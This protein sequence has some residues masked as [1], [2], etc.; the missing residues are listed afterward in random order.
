MP[1]PPR[2]SVV[3]PSFNRAHLLRPTVDSILGQSYPN[4]ECI[5]MDGGSTDGS[6]DILRSYGARIR[7]TSAPDR[8]PAD[9]I[10]HGWAT[11]QGDI[12]AWLNADDLW[13]TPDAASHAVAYLD[14][15]PDVDIVY[16]DAGAVDVDG[17]LTG[18]TYCR[19]WDLTYAVTH[20]DHC[21]P[22]PT[23]FMRRRILEEVGWLDDGLILMDQDLWYRAGLAGTIAYLPITLAHTRR[24]PSYWHA[25]S[26]AIAA[27]CVRIID[28]FFA[29]ADLPAGWRRLERRARSNANLRAV[30]F[31]WMGGRRWDLMRGHA[32]EAVRIDPANAGNAL[33]RLWGYAQRALEDNPRRRWLLQPYDAA[34]R[35]WRALRSGLKPADPSRALAALFSP[36]DMERVWMSFHMP[37]GPGAALDLRAEALLGYVAAQRGFHV[38]AVGPDPGA[39]PYDHPDYRY[40]GG[41]LH[42]AALAAGPYDLILNGGAT[43]VMADDLGAMA[44]LRDALKPGGVMLLTAPAGRDAH[45]PGQG[46]VYGAERLPRLLAGYA[47]SRA[48]F[49]IR[50]GRA[51]WKPCDEPTALQADGSPEARDPAR[52]AYG[53]ACFILTR[54]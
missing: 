16:G 51:V 7:W 40:Q 14:A 23:A 9:A 54:T 38:T 21:I 10:N 24:H 34:R 26:H 2:V 22:Q 32:A 52:E 49:W 33:R 39:W 4:I 25:R 36:R 27:D 28:K 5:V 6:V 35:G 47:V 50:R 29:D 44:R 19:A 13:A 15:H 3:V 53:L 31:A 17:N 45:Y 30:D 18:V 8:G 20:C 42:D 46:R 48:D 43:A 1:E 41:D 12:L 11:S 37:A